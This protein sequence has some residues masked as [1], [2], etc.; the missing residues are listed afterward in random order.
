MHS[1]QYSGR[2]QVAATV[3]TQ[4]YLYSQEATVASRNNAGISTSNAFSSFIS[5]TFIIIFI[6]DFSFHESRR[7]KIG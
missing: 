7:L 3:N 4:T 5:A 1:G 6:V 2:W